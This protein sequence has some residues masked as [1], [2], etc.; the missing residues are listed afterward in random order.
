MDH[1]SCLDWHPSHL[2]GRCMTN[3]LITGATGL[4]G[5]NFARRAVDAGYNVLAMVRQNSDRGAFEG[6]PIQ[7]VEADLEL[8]DTLFAGFTDADIVVHAAAHVG[9]WG[10]AE[11]YRAINV[12]GLE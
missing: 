2:L 12:V 7:F 11:K 5:R 6:V 8:P 10:T 1:I 3:I 9:D 4:V